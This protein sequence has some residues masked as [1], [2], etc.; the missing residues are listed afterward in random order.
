MVYKLSAREE[1]LRDMRI[2]EQARKNAV[3]PNPFAPPVVIEKPAKK[4]G[5]A[6]ACKPAPAR[7]KKSAKRRSRGK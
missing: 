6:A 3:L 1:Q 2:R 4:A 7:K 5:A